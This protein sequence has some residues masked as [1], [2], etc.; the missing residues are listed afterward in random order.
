VDFPVNRVAVYHFD[1]FGLKAFRE[2]QFVG[3]LGGIVQTGRECR[4]TMLVPVV[5]VSIVIIVAL[6]QEK[7]YAGILFGHKYQYR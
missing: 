7:E 6:F 2:E 5:V 1:E 4:L 3:K